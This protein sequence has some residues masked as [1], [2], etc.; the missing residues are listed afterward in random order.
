MGGNSS[1][2]PL[3]TCV[4][5]SYKRDKETVKRALDSVLSQ[6]YSP[7]EIFIIDD[8]RGEGAEEYSRGL[9]EIAKGKE[10][11]RVIKTERGNGAQRA[12]NTGIEKAQGKYI[13]FL[14][15][16]DEWLPEKTGI[17]VKLL[18]ENPDAGLCY[19]K[20]YLIDNTFNPPR[21][22]CFK[23]GEDLKYEDLLLSDRIGTTTQAVIPKAVFE[24][25]GMFDESLPARQDYE[26][27]LRITKEY[28]TVWSKEILYKY[29]KEPGNDQTSHKWEKCLKGYELIHEKYRQDIDKNSSAKF[30]FVV[31]TAHH[32]M[33]GASATGDRSLKLRAVKEYIRSFFISPV[34]F[35][36][37]GKYFFRT[38]W[39]K[40]K[41]FLK[42][43]RNNGK[44]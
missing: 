19:A 10:N 3:V 5:T 23:R 33:E 22:G 7:L 4:I 32:L 28:R 18:E 37:Q 21:I 34:A 38:V 15:D 6:T 39:R 13:A 42:R 29:Y 16:D 11:I 24:K 35:L 41:F 9:R 8:N 44:N 20:G 17:Q 12:R 36:T 43:L 25:V 26:M 30:N 14:D 2:N 31:H 27:W 1:E 40:I